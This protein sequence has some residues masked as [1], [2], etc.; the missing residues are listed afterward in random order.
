MCA[1]IVSMVSILLLTELT[2]KI[3]SKGPPAGSWT[4]R[5][6]NNP[7]N[8]FDRSLRLWPGGAT[9]DTVRSDNLHGSIAGLT[10]NQHSPSM[11]KH[12]SGTHK[13]VATWRVDVDAI[14]RIQDQLQ[15][16]GGGYMVSLSWK[17]LMTGLTTNEMGK[18]PPTGAWTLK[19]YE[20]EIER[21]R[22]VTDGNI[23]KMPSLAA[24]EWDPMAVNTR[25]RREEERGGPRDVV[26]INTREHYKEEGSE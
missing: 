24:S 18:G 6:N 17:G 1:G 8:G 4:L 14:Q 2:V 23:G 10:I 26:T 15:G 16:A 21:L 9:M 20:H 11:L 3:S 22:N 25:G 5:P 7:A 19:W 12:Q 13:N